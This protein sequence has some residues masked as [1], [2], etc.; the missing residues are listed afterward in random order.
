MDY[1][2]EFLKALA[3]TLTMEVPVLFVGVRFVFKLGANK[4]MN[5][6]LFFAGILASLCT[7][8]Y[9]WFVLPQFISDYALFLAVGELS[10]FLVEAALYFFILHVSLKRALFLS[11]ICNLISFLLGL[12]MQNLLH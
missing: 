2:L 5:S 11:F 8:P 3:L 7:L 1:T 12:L 4:I 10:V 9:L 6:T